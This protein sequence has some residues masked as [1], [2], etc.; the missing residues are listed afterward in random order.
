M[1]NSI[2]INRWLIY[3]DRY[4]PANKQK[5]WGNFSRF[6]VHRGKFV[7]CQLAQSFHKLSSNKW[8]FVAV[9]EW[10]YFIES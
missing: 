8:R 2:Q 10:I 7:V 4:E 3:R 1:N 9:S 5:F 6:M